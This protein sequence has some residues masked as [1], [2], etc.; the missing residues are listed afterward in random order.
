MFVP[1][2]RAPGAA[3]HGGQ[4][5]VGV[6]NEGAPGRADDFTSNVQGDV[7]ACT[8]LNL[9]TEGNHRINKNARVVRYLFKLVVKVA[10]RV[11]H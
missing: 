10:C 1:G 4:H 2:A 9:E 3:E 8:V 5:G 6:F 11:I 7:L